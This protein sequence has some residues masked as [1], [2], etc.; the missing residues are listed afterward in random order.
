MFGLFLDLGLAQELVGDEIAEIA[1]PEAPDQTPDIFDEFCVSRSAD[2][3][4]ADV[5]W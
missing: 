2:M 5:P 3:Q 4:F 1:D